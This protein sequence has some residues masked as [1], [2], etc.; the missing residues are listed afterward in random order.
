MK[1]GHAYGRAMHRA[2]RKHRSVL[3]D[4]RDQALNRLHR[5]RDSGCARKVRY[6]TQ[7]AA[8]RHKDSHTAG[9]TAYS[10]RFCSGWHLSSKG[11]T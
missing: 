4:Q 3:K 1:L 2:L 6:L 8:E 5:H 7:A 11:L 9:C 10:C